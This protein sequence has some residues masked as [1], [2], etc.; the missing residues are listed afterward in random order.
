MHARF[1]LPPRAFTLVELL[2]VIA[3]IGILVGLLLP[4]VQYSRESARRSSCANNLHNQVLALQVFHDASHRLPPG[5]KHTGVLETSWYLDIMSQLEQR[6]ITDNYNWTL[7]WNDPQGNL[8]LANTN[9]TILR[10]PSS[11]EEFPGDTDYG[12][13]SGSILTSH[14][15]NIAFDNG[16]LIDV[17]PTNSPINFGAVIDGLSHTMC[18]AESPD[19][20]ADGGGRWISGANCFSHDNGQVNLSDQG[21]IRS[22]HQTGANVALSDG[23]VR[24][25]HRNVEAFVVG[26]L[27]TR[28]LGE[29]ISDDAF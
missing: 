28:N 26:A 22:R 23:S 29:V 15:W 7:P 1:T 16:V 17:P 12:G 11:G 18:I 14:D 3:I 10:C 5:K 4:A 6:H 13:I 27:C 8:T 19:R 25:L 24:Y 9:L 20:S 2:V 21:E